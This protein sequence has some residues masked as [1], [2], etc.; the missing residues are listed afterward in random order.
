ML[1]FLVIGVTMKLF[2]F[3]LLC[4]LSYN[5]FANNN[6]MRINVIEYHDQPPFI[7]N[8]VDKKG[9]SF[10]IV[11]SLNAKSENFLYQL[12]ILPKKRAQ[13][14]IADW[15][16]GN[17]F[18][19]TTCDENWVMLWTN[20]QWGWGKNA[21][22]N[23]LWLPIFSD[24]DAI[25]SHVD[26]NIN[27]VNARS[28]IGFS[29]G[30]IAGHHYQG[31]DELVAAKKIVRNDTYDE[32]TLILRVLKKRVDCIALQKSALTFYLTG[33]YA[34]DVKK[35]RVSQ[36]HYQHFI[37]SSM[38]PPQRADLKEEMYQLTQSPEWQLLFDKYGLDAIY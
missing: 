34:P 1:L 7:I 8:K 5:G 2:F 31:I 6:K 12:S 30:G 29:F 22:E 18:E 33:R 11:N 26:A 32:E 19:S 28:L 36:Q 15:I 21:K 23:Y 17:C 4:L 3:T 13:L 14:T 16:N 27:F 24:Y 25:V 20:P 9:L 37:A 38:F 10:D 35:L